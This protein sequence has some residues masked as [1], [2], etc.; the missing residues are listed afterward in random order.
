MCMGGGS[1]PAPPPL[2]PPVPEPARP[3]DPNVVAASEDTKKRAALAAGSQSTIL[4]G[5]GALTP[6]AVGEKKNLL[7]Q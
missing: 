2:P 5:P 7:G 6:A 4:T 1:Q 3:S